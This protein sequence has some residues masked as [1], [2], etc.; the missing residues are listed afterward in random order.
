[1]TPTHRFW[2][3]SFLL[4]AVSG[5]PSCAANSA[6]QPPFTSNHEALALDVPTQFR[7]VAFGDTRFHDPADTEAANAVVRQTLVKAI[8]EEKPAFV[9]IGGDIVYSGDNPKDWQ[10]W[11]SETSHWQEHKIVVYPA[12]GNHDLHG[13]QKT[14]LGNYFARFPALKGSRF[15]SV[16][17][18]DS[19][20]LVL[21]SALDELTGPQGEWLH[22]QL[23]HLA[24]NIDF[25]F[26]VFHHPP[27]TSSSDEKVFGGGHSAREK[28]ISLAAFLEE[29]QKQARAR[30]VVFNGHVH[31]Y[32]RHEHNGVIYFVTGGG[33]AHPYP[34]TR[35]ADDPYK[36]AGVNY[37][38]LL[39]DVDKSRARITMKKLELK[40]GKAVWTQPDEI[41]IPATVAKAA[42]AR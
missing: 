13:D 1:M 26:F 32:E 20:M 22:G 23:D 29:K 4:L 34:I 37:H 18:G 10:V 33:G 36:D 31:N 12:L 25:V 39:V 9:S 5:L 3:A 35:K 30:F 7:F 21:D 27:Y 15:Y 2:L 8:D 28:E 42:G 11:D 19:L 17:I 38:Y 41:V 24:S 6:D 40:D 16:Q 14:T